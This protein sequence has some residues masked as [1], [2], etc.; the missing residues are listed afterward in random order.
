[1]KFNN[2]SSLEAETFGHLEKLA[3]LDLAANYIRTMEAD[4]F[5]GIP[6]LKVLS[7]AGN[8]LTLSAINDSLQHLETLEELYLHR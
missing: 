7:L 8:Q 5:K 4:A 1:M 2:I 6:N 3:E